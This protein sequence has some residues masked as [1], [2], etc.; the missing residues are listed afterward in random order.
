MLLN[1]EQPATGKYAFSHLG[2]RPFFL[3]AGLWAV[4]GMLLWTGIYSFDWNILPA[5]YPASLWHAHEMIFGYAGAVMAGFLLTAV[6]N[7]TNQQTIHQRPLLLLAGLWLLARVLPL[8]SFIPL[9]VVAVIETVF[10][11]WLFWEL[12]RPI[13]KVKQWRQS[14]IL[15]KMLLFPVANAVFYLGLFGYWDAGVRVGLYA[16]LYIVLGLIFTMGRRVIPFFIE[17]SVGYPFEAQNDVWLDRFSLL[18]FVGFALADTWVMATGS[19]TAGMLA[20][21]F[22]LAQVPLHIARLAG[23]YHPNVWEQPLLWVLYLAYVWLILGFLLKFLVFAT[24]ISANLAT[25]AFTYGG[26][27]LITIGIMA[28]VTLGHTG[29]NIFESPAIL[30]VV[31]LLLFGGAFLRVFNAWLVPEFYSMWILSAQ[32]LWITAFALFVWQYL[33]ILIRPRVDGHYG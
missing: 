29:R 31:F 16:G 9:S 2:F 8:L 13:Q 11:S 27:G 3:G 23:W 26:V 14:A 22:A 25:H 5:T 7:W 32:L 19:V 24:G 17:R 21:L 15:G 12:L 33:P 28:R 18:L 10:L 20:A 4:F 30:V 1:I 6:K